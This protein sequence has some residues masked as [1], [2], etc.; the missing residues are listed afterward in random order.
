MGVYDGARFASARGEC[1]AGTAIAG[2]QRQIQDHP[3]GFRAFPSHVD[4]GIIGLMDPAHG[5]F[6]HQSWYWRS[7]HSIHEKEK[8]FEPI[9]LG[10]RI[11]SKHEPSSNSAPYKLLRYFRGRE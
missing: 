2:I 5:P 4:Q 6:V 1:S 7:R 8:H 9:P 11:E 10:F 3:A